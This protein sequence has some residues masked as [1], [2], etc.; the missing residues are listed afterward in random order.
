[1]AAWANLSGMTSFSI[2]SSSMTGTLPNE[3]AT[4]WPKLT[5]LDLGSNRLAGKVPAHAHRAA[6]CGGPEQVQAGKACVM[7]LTE[8]GLLQAPSQGLGRH[9]RCSTLTCATTPLLV[10]GVVLCQCRYVAAAGTHAHA[11][12]IHQCPLC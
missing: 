8:E 3:L 2:I 7:Q 9:C 10:C 5:Y 6:G 4:A 1:M 12:C 11:M